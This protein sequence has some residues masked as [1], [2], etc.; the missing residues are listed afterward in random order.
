MKM[1]FWDQAEERTFMKETRTAVPGG[2]SHSGS[3]IQRGRRGWSAARVSQERASGGHHQHR[4]LDSA[5][6]SFGKGAKDARRLRGKGWG[7]PSFSCSCHWALAFFSSQFIEGCI[8]NFCPCSSL[9]S[10]SLSPPS[11]SSRRACRPPI[12]MT[13]I[14]RPSNLILSPTLQDPPLSPPYTHTPHRPQPLTS[15]S[16][17]PHYPHKAAQDLHP[18]RYPRSLQQTLQSSPAGFQSFS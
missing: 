11:Q 3:H 6:V 9:N 2:G 10:T 13:T 4:G 16:Q 7:H 12:F 18:E 5:P 17:T 15:P 8:L 14:F 1:T